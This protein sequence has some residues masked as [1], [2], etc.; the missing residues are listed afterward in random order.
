[1]ELLGND[2]FF[3]SVILLLGLAIGFVIG[4]NNSPDMSMQN[5]LAE[6]LAAAQDELA[7]YKQLIPNHE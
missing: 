3:G 4:R 6:K 7:D 1:M 2:W 5:Q